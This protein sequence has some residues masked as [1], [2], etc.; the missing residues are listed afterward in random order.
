M[1]CYAKLNVY[2]G[3]GIGFGGDYNIYC[4]ICIALR[5]VLVLTQKKSKAKLEA[6]MKLAEK[7]LTTSKKP[8]LMR[9]N[10]A[11]R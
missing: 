11:F 8:L 6:L 5:R 3:G 4:S 10:V 1:I 2:L 9:R 7:R